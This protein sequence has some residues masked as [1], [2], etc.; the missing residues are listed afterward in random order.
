MHKRM[1]VMLCILLI[2][3]LGCSD[4][5]RYDPGYH[6]PQ[7]KTVLPE[8]IEDEQDSFPNEIPKL[9]VDEKD[10]VQRNTTAR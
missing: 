10:D 8:S 3:V 2:G 7:E 5:V 6:E 1:G 9:V 4:V